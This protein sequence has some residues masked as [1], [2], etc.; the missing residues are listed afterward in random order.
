MWYYKIP[1]MKQEGLWDGSGWAVDVPRM[2]DSA[3][4]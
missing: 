2:V 3:D 4:R 1:E